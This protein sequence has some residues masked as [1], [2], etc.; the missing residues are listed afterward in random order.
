VVGFDHLVGQRDVAAGEGVNGAPDLR[1]DQPAHRQHAGADRAEV[2]V[3]L[4]GGVI[5][6][7]PNRPVM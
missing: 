3:V 2:E 5:A 4:L 6:H 7:Q 1:L